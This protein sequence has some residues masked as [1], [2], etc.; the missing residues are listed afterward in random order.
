MTNDPSRARALLLAAS[1]L[2]VLVAGSAWYVLTRNVP[3]PAVAGVDSE[4]V[5]DGAPELTGAPPRPRV[6]ASTDSSVAIRSSAGIELD[7]VLLTRADGSWRSLWVRSESL[8]R[9]E[10]ASAGLI[11]APGHR[12]QPVNPDA[13]AIVLEVDAMLIVRAPGLRQ[14]LRR[15]KVV[16]DNRRAGG[17]GFLDD[18]RVAVT[19]ARHLFSADE[20]EPE[21]SFVLEWNDCFSTLLVFRPTGD[22]TVEW[23]TSCPALPDLEPLVLRVP[24]GDASAGTP[25]AV[26]KTATIHA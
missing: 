7:T 19:V 21:C 22:G 15:V 16:P 12:A 18:E 10:L 2:L 13:A 4:P 1:I 24:R 3:V 11:S 20:E 23:A 8:D 9:A 5:I 14:C 26:S 17:A 25:S 6:S